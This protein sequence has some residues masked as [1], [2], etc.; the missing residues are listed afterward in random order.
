MRWKT[1]ES[2]SNP[3]IEEARYQFFIQKLVLGIITPIS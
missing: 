3:K 1:T 2:L